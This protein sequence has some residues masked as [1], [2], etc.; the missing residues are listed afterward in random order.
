M[1][2]AALSA[3]RMAAVQETSRC[4][5]AEQSQQQHQHPFPSVP[6]TSREI[7]TIEQTDDQQLHCQKC[8]KLLHNKVMLFALP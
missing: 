3:Q 6:S 5:N 2:T 7:S 4:N 8:H 1:A